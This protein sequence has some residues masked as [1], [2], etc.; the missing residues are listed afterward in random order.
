MLCVHS[1]S[2]WT[3]AFLSTMD[4]LR[5]PSKSVLNYA[6]RKLIQST[7]HQRQRKLRLNSAYLI[8]SL[9]IANKRFDP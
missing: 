9:L 8:Y 6:V 4:N 1:P 3:R 7:F 5:L 2:A